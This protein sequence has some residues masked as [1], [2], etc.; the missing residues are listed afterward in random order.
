MRGLFSNEEPIQMDE[1]T[2]TYAVRPRPLPGESTP[3]FLMRVASA[4]GFGSVPQL[5]TSLR[6]RTRPAFDELCA[7]LCLTDD[8][9]GYLFGALPSQWG[10]DT[11]PRGLCLSDFNHTCRRWCPACLK[12]GLFLQGRWSLKLACACTRHAAWLQDVCAKCGTTTRWSDVDQQRCQCGASLPEAPTEHVTGNVLRVTKLLCGDGNYN[13]ELGDDVKLSPAEAHRMVRYLGLFSAQIRPAHP[14]QIADLHRMPMARALVLG[15]ADFLESWPSGI[16]ALMAKLQ[17]SVPQSPS[18]RKT[19][20]PLYRVLY[21]DLSDPCFQFLRDAFEGYLREHWQGLVCRRN[22]LMKPQTVAAHPW[23]TLPQMAAAAS[24][25][26]SVVRHL[27]QGKLVSAATALLPSGRQSRTLHLGDL[28]HIRAATEGAVSIEQA[29][30]VLKLPERRMRT[31]IAE[32]VIMPIISRQLTPNAA[33]WLISKAEIDRLHVQPDV[34]L[35]GEGIAVRDVLKYWRLREHED[36]SFIK[37][38]LAR[39]LSAKAQ[40]QDLVPLGV[41]TFDRAAI[42]QW[43]TSSRSE[44]G[45]G[46]SIDQVAHDMGVKQQVAYELMRQGLLTTAQRGTLGNRV[47]TSDLQRFRATYVSLADLARTV[48]RSPRTLLSEMSAMPVCGP[49]VNGARQYFF[50]RVDLQSCW[51]ELKF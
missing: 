7:R 25:P 40:K 30:R 6:V 42:K 29:A 28:V 48:H 35:T 50:R 27:V 19:F 10:L 11:V 31:L 51:G 1:P 37:A 21:K 45:E 12:E 47:M 2:R 34:A 49:A 26:T 8:E 36:I 3:G 14:G 13:A 33:A 15:A 24:V 9:R 39:K 43:L 32:G 22:K 46:L 17:V 16:H 20:F 44:L 41:A 38:V 4:N 18:V 23:L 5:Y